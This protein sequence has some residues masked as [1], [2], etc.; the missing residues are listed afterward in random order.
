MPCRRR[1]RS[2]RTEAWVETTPACLWGQSRHSE[3]ADREPGDGYICFTRLFQLVY[4]VRKRITGDYAHLAGPPPQRAGISSLNQ[5][6]GN[7]R[8]VASVFLPQQRI[9]VC[10]LLDES[11]W[12]CLSVR[13]VVEN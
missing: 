5:Q 4:T 8:A 11:D 7:R 10:L 6:A 2:C 3:S 12:V 1:R 13:K 9:V